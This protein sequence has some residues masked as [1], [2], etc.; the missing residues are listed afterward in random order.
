LLTPSYTTIASASGTSPKDVVVITWPLAAHGGD[1][2]L[3]GM[4]VNV[5]DLILSVVIVR[6]GGRSSKHRRLV[7]AGLCLNPSDWDY[8]M[9]RLKRGMTNRELDDVGLS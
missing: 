4:G 5:A 9:P 2:P 1:P 7:L 6:V 8:W 3:R